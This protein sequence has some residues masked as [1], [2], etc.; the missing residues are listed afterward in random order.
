MAAA[1]DVSAAVGFV[2]VTPSDS[3]VFAATRA[4]YVGV[5]GDIVVDGAKRGTQVTLT[6]AAAGEHPWQ[7]TRVY[8]TGTT[9]TG[10]VALY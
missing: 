10:I 2:A 5:A 3:I 1:S 8:S 6:A 7:V 9:A 4:L